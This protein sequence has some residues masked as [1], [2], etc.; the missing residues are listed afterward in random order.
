M[1]LK[2]A[3][4]ETHFCRSKGVKV[5][6]ISKDGSQITRVLKNHNLHKRKM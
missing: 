6:E 3:K 4:V 1:F 2:V 5:F